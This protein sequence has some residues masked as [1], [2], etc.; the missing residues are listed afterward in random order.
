MDAHTCTYTRVRT[1]CKE[2][3]SGIAQHPNPTSPEG[4]PGTGGQPGSPSLGPW[5]SLCGLGGSQASEA[6]LLV[7]TVRNQGETILKAQGNLW[8]HSRHDNAV[9]D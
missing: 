9:L 6:P 3:Q 1:H 5:T 4:G 8:A 2:E 7:R